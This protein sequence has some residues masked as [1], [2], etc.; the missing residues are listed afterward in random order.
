[1]TYFV[2]LRA[3]PYGS[4]CDPY[5][6]EGD[7]TATPPAMTSVF[8]NALPILAKGKDVLLAAHGFNVSYENGLCSLGHLEAALNMQP[9]ELFLGVLWPGDWVI[10]AVNYPFEDNI[11]SHG[12]ALLG[13]FCNRCLASARSIS[14]LS[15][16]LGA[17]VVLEAIKASTRQIRRACIIAGAVNAG[18]LTEEYKG[19]AKNCGEIRTLSSMMDLVLEFAYP[20]GDLM[21]NILDPD[22]PFFEPALG[23]GGPIAPYESTV[24]PSEIAKSPP[25]YD[26]SDYFPPS[27]PTLPRVSPNDK[28]RRAVA[29]MASA[30]RGQTPTWP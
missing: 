20:P 22:H 23:R 3:G 24:L 19:A 7:G 1:M 16:S 8:W 17:R 30:F 14:F 15:H 2:D 13:S 21:A 9:N 28:W 12:G 18:C 25:Y 10:P 26:H 6:L 4:V 29:F 27:I 5:V 11:A